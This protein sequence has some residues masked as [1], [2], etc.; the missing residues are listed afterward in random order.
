MTVSLLSWIGKVLG[1]SSA[2]AGKVSSQNGGL[3]GF[4][5]TCPVNEVDFRG[6]TGLKGQASLDL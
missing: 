3:P 1:S 2:W 6:D 4:T 5:L